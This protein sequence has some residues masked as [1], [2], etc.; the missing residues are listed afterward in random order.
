MQINNKIYQI[1]GGMYAN[2]SNIYVILANNSL[3][4]VDCA[5]TEHDY[6][7]MQ[8]NLKKWNLDNYPISNVLIS[9]KHFGHIGNARRLQKAGACIIA[10][11]EDAK[12]IETGN[13]HEIL[14]YSPFPE[15]D[16]YEPCKVDLKVKDQEELILDGIAI[17]CISAPGHTRGSM[18]YQMHLDGQSILF[19]GDVIG[20]TKD[21]HGASLGWEGGVDFDTKSYWETIKKLSSYPCDQL[22][23]G[24]GQLCLQQGTR[25]LQMAK[26]E[27]LCKFRK[28]SIENE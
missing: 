12:A 25:I 8:E 22:L 4:M 17:T 6:F 3:I 26:R 11:I 7:V 14:D 2:V 20:V 23:P 19:T 24:H 16:V 5:E 9:H 15:H 21:C 10:G 28:P 18:I 27:A 13:I 1:L